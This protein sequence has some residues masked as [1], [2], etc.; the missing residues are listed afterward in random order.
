MCYKL[1]KDELAQISK[2]TNEKLLDQVEYFGDYKT[3]IEM[4]D[5]NGIAH[6]DDTDP[7]VVKMKSDYKSV[8]DELLSRLTTPQEIA[9]LAAVEDGSNQI[10]LLTASNAK[11]LG[12]PAY[13][14]TPGQVVSIKA[15]YNSNREDLVTTLGI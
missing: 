5:A 6:K 13:D 2:W 4:Q 7:D 10:A 9:L 3:L 14:T 15:Q 11:A 8:R 1:K 12:I